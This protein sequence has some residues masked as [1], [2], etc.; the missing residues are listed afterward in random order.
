MIKTYTVHK[1]R[2]RAWP[3]RFGLYLSKKKIRFRVAFDNSCRYQLPG[4]DQQDINKLFGL[5]YFPNHHKES[6]RFGWVY[7]PDINKI[8]L[9][10]YCYVNGKRITDQITTVP[11]HQ[12]FVLE[13]NISATAYSFTVFKE[14]F[15]AST[16]IQHSNKRK[17]SFPL[18]VYFGG[19]QPA[20]H[21]ITI[22]M[23]KA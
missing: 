15:Q 13:L 22:E 12:S 2:H 9:Y 16:H 23:K 18:G 3:F 17:W 1:G 19:N 4:E 7:N 21:K 11:L 10:A 20:P 6:A 14:S 8:E 5:G